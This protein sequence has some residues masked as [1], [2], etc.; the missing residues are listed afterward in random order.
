VDESLVIREKSLIVVQPW[1]NVAYLGKHLDESVII[2]LELA[3]DLEYK[4]N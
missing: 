3:C 4:E 2:L 1:K